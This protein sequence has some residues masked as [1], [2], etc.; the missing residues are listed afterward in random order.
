[1]MAR[2]GITGAIIV[3]HPFRFD[4]KKAA[5]VTSPHYRLIASG[6]IEGAMTVHAATGWVTKK[7]RTLGKEGEVFGVIKYVLTH[8]GVKDGRH[9]VTYTG[10][11]HYSK[12]K[13]EPE[14]PE[15][16][17]CP[18]CPLELMQLRLTVE[19]QDRPPPFEEGFV[20]LVSY[21]CLELIDDFDFHVYG[22]G[23]RVKVS[24]RQAAAE[25]R[26]ER[27]RPWPWRYGAPRRRAARPRACPPGDV[28]GAVCVFLES[29]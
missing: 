1:V 6:W 8:A 12:L 7:I 21:G 14:E 28:L 13:L 18:Y 15:P 26:A 10:L 20:G 22:E 25:R 2:V 9:A 17:Q 5:P 3:L 11:L 24:S 16:S 23:W 29:D 19:A 27:G 4:G